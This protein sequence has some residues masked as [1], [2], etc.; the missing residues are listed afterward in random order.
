[1]EGLYATSGKAKKKQI[2]DKEKIDWGDKVKK[3][4]I[5]DKEKIDWGDEA[6][7]VEDQS[8]LAPNGQIE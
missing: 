2:L 6:L 3:K 4:Q 1:M 8:L 5:L 7:V